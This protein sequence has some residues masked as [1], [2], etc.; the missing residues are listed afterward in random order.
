MP[1]F[2]SRTYLYSI[3]IFFLVHI[4]ANVSFFKK[5]I[6]YIVIT[7]LIILP[8]FIKLYVVTGNWYFLGID[9][10]A[11]T[12]DRLNRIRIIATENDGLSLLPSIGLDIV[13]SGLTNILFKLGLIIYFLFV[14]YNYKTLFIMKKGVLYS[15]YVSSFFIMF[16]ENIVTGY[17]LL[18]LMLVSIVINKSYESK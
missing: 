6:D 11:L 15:L 10:N 13:D 14:Y 12:S 8:V 9:I 3:V 5:A 7:F 17:V 4:F 16:M 2:G 18:P 1:Y